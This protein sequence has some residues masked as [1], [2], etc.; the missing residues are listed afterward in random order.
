MIQ[1]FP[2]QTPEQ[3]RRQAALYRRMARSLRDHDAAARFEARADQ[4]EAQADGGGAVGQ[5]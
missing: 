3:L 2:P 4:Y 5:R 1:A